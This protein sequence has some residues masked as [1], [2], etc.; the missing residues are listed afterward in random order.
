MEKFDIIQSMNNRE[1]PSGLDNIDAQF[2][3]HKNKMQS[4]PNITGITY[5]SPEHEVANS[6]VESFSQNEI[7]RR[8]SESSLDD[9]ESDPNLYRALLDSCTE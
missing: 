4:D 7:R 9:W 5:G 6:L 1:N 3:E 8:I 2:A